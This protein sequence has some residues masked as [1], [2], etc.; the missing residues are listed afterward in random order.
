MV[1]KR[2]GVLVVNQALDFT[3]IDYVITCGMPIID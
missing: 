2:S 1:N 3:K